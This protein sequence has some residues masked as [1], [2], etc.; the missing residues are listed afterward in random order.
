MK[1]TEHSSTE[2][3]RSSPVFEIEKKL[4]SLLPEGFALGV[5]DRSLAHPYSLHPQEVRFVSPRAT[6]KRKEEFFMG[7]AAAHQ[8]LRNLGEPVEPVGKGPSGAPAWPESATGSI[9]H[10]DG[11]A[12]AVA[13][14]AGLCKAVGVDLETVAGPVSLGISRRVCRPEEIPWV[15]EDPSSFDLRLKLIF[16]AKESVYKAVNC[17]NKG[18]LSFSDVHLRWRD[19]YERFDVELIPEKFRDGFSRK[20]SIVQCIVTDRAIVTF[21][22]LW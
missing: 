20:P 14:P 5:A 6:L 19:R 11:M 9:T 10:K 18:F 16:S 3:D 17:F 12:L 13:A 1:A 8:A 21:F 2:F 15:F 4:S 22:I 7:R